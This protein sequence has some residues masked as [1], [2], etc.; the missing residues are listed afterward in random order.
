MFGCSLAG[1][2]AVLI[3]LFA[4]LGGRLG[5]L[6]SRILAR[7]QRDCVT[8]ARL[9]IAIRIFLLL[10]FGA[11][12]VG[13]VVLSYRGTIESHTFQLLIPKM[14]GQKSEAWITLRV[15]VGRFDATFSRTACHDGTK[16]IDYRSN[17][18]RTRY[19]AG[20]PL[21]LDFYRGDAWTFAGF[22][23]DRREAI[24]QNPALPRTLSTTRDTFVTPWWFIVLLTGLPAG[25]LAITLRYALRRKFS[26]TQ[27][28]TCGYDLRAGHEKCPECGADSHVGVGA[29]NVTDAIAAPSGPSGQR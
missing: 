18:Q 26:A 25:Y 6:Y 29:P 8:I 1:F 4:S 19:R 24:G 7:N 3:R 14:P 9:R 12:F 10:V 13:A 2:R 15:G 22:G 20:G 16:W 21:I 28:R 5:K 27:C 23:F 11:A 17:G